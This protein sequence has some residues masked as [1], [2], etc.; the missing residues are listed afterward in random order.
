M[1]SIATM[2]EPGPASAEERLLLF[3]LG[4][5]IYGTSLEVVREIVPWRRPTRLPGAPSYVV[6][7][8]N[9]RGTIVTVAD[10]GTR[11]GVA[12]GERTDS[13]IVLVQAGQRLM[14]FLVDEVKDVRL[15][16]A[17]RVERPGAGAESESMRGIVRGMG[18]LDDEVVILVDLAALAAEILV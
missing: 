6:G 4:G 1:G 5:R 10:L 13:S 18:H 7:L 12:T 9:L 11:L 14:G 16:A 17:D 8:I 2:T 15:L 3:R